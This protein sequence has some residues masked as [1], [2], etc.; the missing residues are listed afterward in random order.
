MVAFTFNFLDPDAVRVTG[1]F[2]LSAYVSG[3]TKIDV[4][5][6]NLPAGLDH[7]QVILDFGA[8]NATCKSVDTKTGVL[9]F[10]IPTTGTSGAVHLRLHL[11][12]SGETF[13]LPR[14]FDY[15]EQKAAVITSVSPS[16]AS[17][18]TAGTLDPK[19]ETLNPKS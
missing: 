14:T 16:K 12:A 10:E 9:T 5:V 15:L 6:K 17:I 13:D 8:S 7:A 3:R 1:F 18:R 11:L 2:P 19:P 4:E